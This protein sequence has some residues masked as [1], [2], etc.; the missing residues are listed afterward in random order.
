METGDGIRETGS[1][2]RDPRWGS[3]MTDVEFVLSRDQRDEIM[4]AVRAIERQVKEMAGSL[5]WQVVY[6]IGTN[7]A[8]IQANLTNLPPASSN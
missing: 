3:E 2:I 7:L 6:V 8:I 5:T 4:R 1:G